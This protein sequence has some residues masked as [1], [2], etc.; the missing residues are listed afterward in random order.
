[1][2]V[3]HIYNG[4]ILNHISVYSPALLK[5]SLDLACLRR[6]PCRSR[7]IQI[8]A[9]TKTVTLR[10]SSINQ[11]ILNNP[12]QE[13][14]SGQHVSLSEANEE[15]PAHALILEH[16]QVVNTVQHAKS[17]VFS[18]IACNADTVSFP[19]REIACTSLLNSSSTQLITKSCPV[20][21]KSYFFR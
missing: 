12:M 3:P 1:M 8:H 21:A 19:L 4:T 13:R 14:D 17:L 9:L 16:I 20:M 5:G 11:R 18:P 6:N 15:L 7:Q 10:Y 2:E